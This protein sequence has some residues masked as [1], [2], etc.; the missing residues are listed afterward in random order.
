MPSKDDHKFNR[1]MDEV[2][3]YLG[4]VKSGRRV[5]KQ[6][7]T[8]PQFSQAYDDA[9]LASRGQ[10]PAGAGTPSLPQP[11]TIQNSPWG[12]RWRNAPASPP[13]MSNVKPGEHVLTL[14]SQHHNILQ[15]AQQLQQSSFG[16]A[17]PN[18]NNSP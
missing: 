16:F 8:A 3:K 9:R 15:K 11:Q 13:N 12:D 14:M 7:P 2:R 10:V 5:P 17:Q 18:V 1:Y 4:K 6:D